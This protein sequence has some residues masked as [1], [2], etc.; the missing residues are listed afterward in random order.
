MP[1]P[2]INGTLQPVRTKLAVRYDAQK[3]YTTTEDWDGAGSKSLD[4][5]ANESRGAGMDYTLDVSPVKSRLVRTTTGQLAGGG[6]PEATTS[7]WQLFTNE[8]Q[9]D[10]REHPAAVALGPV[11]IRKIEAAIKMI[12]VTAAQGVDEDWILTGL[13]QTYADFTAVDGPFPPDTDAKGLLDLMMH[14]VTSFNVTGYSVRATISLPFLFTGAL[15]AIAPDSL[16]AGLIAAIPV[17]IPSST[18]FRWGWRPMGSSRTFSGNRTEINR[19]W[20][21]SSWSRLLYPSDITDLP[22]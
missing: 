21:L 19:E 5:I 18:F 2:K 17:Q 6:I 22:V 12:E 1:T 13:A 14:G 16:M 4:G 9:K 8:L 20:Q 10:I 15:P 3:G 7:T 11:V